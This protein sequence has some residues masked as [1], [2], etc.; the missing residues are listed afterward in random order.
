[1]SST[2]KEDDLAASI[3]KTMTVDKLKENLTLANVGFSSARKKADFVDL[4]I[5]NGLHKGAVASLKAESLKAESLKAESLKA[6]SLKE[7][8]VRPLEESVR[9]LEESARPVEESTRPVEATVSL[10]KAS[11]PKEEL[12]LSLI[13]S[14]HGE[15]TFRWP[16]D[17]PESNYYKKNVRVYSRG[18][19]PGVA[20]IR[21]RAH[22]ASSIH[23][24]YDI[25]KKNPESATKEIM[26]E[27]TGIDRNYYRNFLDG[28]DKC[29]FQDEIG[30][31]ILENK[32]RCGGLSTYLSNKIFSVVT[33]ETEKSVYVS[34]LD[35]NKFMASRGINVSDI[36]LKITAHDGSVSYRQ[37][38][39]PRDEWHKYWASNPD[40]EKNPFD[41]SKFNLFY[42]NGMEFILKDVLHREDL[43]DSA[44]R[45]FNFKAGKDK[46]PDIS[47]VQLYNFFKL[48]GFKYVNIIDHSCRVFSTGK[49]MTSDESEKLFKEEQKYSVKPVAF[50]KRSEGKRSEGKRRNNKQTRRR[51]RKLNNKKLL[52]HRKYSRKM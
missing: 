39:N 44:L 41:V 4:Y 15:E 32:E 49:K 36:R 38:F 18:C 30:K 43:F 22:V 12:I 47:L 45:A 35:F 1:M 42:R 46:I 52:K 33:D 14:A 6:K 19:V 37:I 40:F 48:V 31:N 11:K 25:F 34:E 17:F 13:I 29:N 9:P 21:N 10:S 7:E 50:G 16:R 26:A 2:K 28:L 51:S 20:T 3:S 5:S 24:A 27:Y 8:S 23:E